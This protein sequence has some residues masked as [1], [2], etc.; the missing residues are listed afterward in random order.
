MCRNG[1]RAFMNTWKVRAQSQHC[2]CHAPVGGGSH[3]WLQALV[4]K[5]L[6]NRRTY[7]EPFGFLAVCKSRHFSLPQVFSVLLT[8]VV[9]PSSCRTCNVPFRP[10]STFSRMPPTHSSDEARKAPARLAFLFLQF[11]SAPPLSHLLTRPILS[12]WGHFQ[13]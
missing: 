11:W 2:A 8:P 9:T 10:A 3:A 4:T 13:V 1:L 5:D 6:R 12:T 7:Q